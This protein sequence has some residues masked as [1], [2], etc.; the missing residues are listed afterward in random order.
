MDRQI[1][2]LEVD[3]VLSLLRSRAEGLSPDEV[4]ERLAELGPNAFAVLYW[5]PVGAVLATG[6]VAPWLVALAALGAP[7]L[8]LADLARKRLARPVAR[9]GP[10]PRK[11]RT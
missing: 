4:A 3:E 1:H 10:L 2:N 9:G 11:M 6:P 5:A 8:F 7:I